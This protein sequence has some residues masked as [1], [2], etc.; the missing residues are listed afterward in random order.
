MN[1]AGDNRFYIP[2]IKFP[3]DKVWYYLEDI[4]KIIP[5]PLPATSSARHF[6][7]VPEIWAKYRKR[8][9]WILTVLLLDFFPTVPCTLVP[10]EN[11][12]VVLNTLHCTLF[13]NCIVHYCVI[14]E[15]FTTETLL[16]ITD[17]LFSLPQCMVFD[18]LLKWYE[19][20]NLKV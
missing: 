9:I 16:F 19:W 14:V 13:M 6:S 18:D 12:Q 5:E 15:V 20:I 10:Q 2:S 4:K 11:S 8:M 3:G 17:M 7:V 1:S